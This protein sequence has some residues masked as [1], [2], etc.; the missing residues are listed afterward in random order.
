MRERLITSFAL[1]G[2]VLVVAVALVVFQFGRKDPSPPS[3]E[4]TPIP[5]IPGE[6][7]F[8]NGDNCVVRAAAS[9]ASREEVYCGYPEVLTKTGI[10]SVVWI[11]ENTIGFPT[12]SQTDTTRLDIIEVDLE[13]KEETI[14]QNAA[15]AQSLY[16]EA[17]V[18][19]DGERAEVLDNGTLVYTVS[20]ERTEIAKFDAEPYQV[21]PVVWSPDSQWL[22]VSYQP[23]HSSGRELWVISRDGSVQGTLVEG[24]SWQESPSDQA[25]WLIPGIG[26]TPVLQ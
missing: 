22:V 18:S 17:A 24:S 13:T 23:P 5:A 3:L 26:I 19:P 15:S 16:R 11:D 25:S 2:L 6:I 10:G 9:G 12:I 7:L 4:D 8:R 20:G 21:W 1:G 14:R